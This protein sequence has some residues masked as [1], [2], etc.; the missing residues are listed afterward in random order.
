MTPD[1][2]EGLLDWDGAAAYL[3]TTPRHVKTLTREAKLEHVRI[4]RKIRFT[5]KG[6]DA[7]IR[8]NTTAGR[9]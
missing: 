9:S 7:F 1:T 3:G 6:L 5:R 8:R 4:G 2:I